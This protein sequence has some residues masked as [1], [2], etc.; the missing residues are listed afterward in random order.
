MNPF[1]LVAGLLAVLLGA[2]HS[3]L[4]EVL[5]FRHLRRKGP[6]SSSGSPILTGRQVRTLR[7][8]WHLVSWFGWGFAAILLHWS[9]SASSDAHLAFAQS[10]MMVTFLTSALYWLVAT[11]GKHPAWIVLLII[12]ILIGLA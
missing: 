8:T 12:G 10:V 2:I 11:K 3:V 9:G 4:G 5:I 6:V 1:F 7:A